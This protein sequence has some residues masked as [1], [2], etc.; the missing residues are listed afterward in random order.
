MVSPSGG[1]GWGGQ[2]VIKTWTMRVELLGVFSMKSWG[3]TIHEENKAL[4]VV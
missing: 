1:G 3:G 2:K 4:I